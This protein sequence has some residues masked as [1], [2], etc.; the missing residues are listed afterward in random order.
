MV[1]ISLGADMACSARSCKGLDP[2]KSQHFPRLGQRP[3]PTAKV[4]ILDA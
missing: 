1:G 2:S 3:N 4:P